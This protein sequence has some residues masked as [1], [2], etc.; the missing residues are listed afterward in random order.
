MNQ[1]RIRCSCQILKKGTRNGIKYLIPSLERLL[2]ISVGFAHIPM[3]DGDIYQKSKYSYQIRIGP[4]LT[5]ERQLKTLAHELVH[6]QQFVEERLSYSFG[7]VLWEGDI[8]D[9]K[10]ILYEDRP[11]EIE[12]ISRTDEVLARLR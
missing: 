6:V 5:L 10:K 12:A 3:N 8:F 1:T 2:F 4:L 9:K 11:W 7:L